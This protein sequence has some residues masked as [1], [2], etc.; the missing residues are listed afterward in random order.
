MEGC[1]DLAVATAVQAMPV[2]LA[3][4]D[5]DQCDAG[6]AGELGVGGEAV[7]AGDLADQLG[8]GQRTEAGLGEQVGSDRGRPDR[9]SRPR[10]R[11]SSGSARAGGA[12]RRG[13]SGRASSA[14]RAR[15]VGRSWCSTCFEN[16]APPGSIELG[17]TDRADSTERAVEPHRDGGPSARGDRP[18][19]GD[20]APGR[21]A[22]RSAA[23]RPLR[24]RPL[25][26]QRARRCGRTWRAP[27]RPARRGHQPGRDADDALAAGDQKP[28]QGA[29]HVPAVL[30]RPDPLALL[31]RAP[32]APAPPNPRA[33]T[34]TVFSPSSWP[35][36]RL[37]RHDRM[38]ALVHVRTEHDH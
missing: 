24:A 11:R 1:V 33:P 14:R 8:C 27:A 21:R 29:G 30:K 25:G 34:A 2:G 15:G 38:R 4:A 23:S 3:R 31:V 36:P 26:R 35:V 20:R 32:R 12:A 10:A 18:A 17:A 9:R 19:A 7:G 22:P 37:N 6:G 16:S 5:G 28:L 13:R